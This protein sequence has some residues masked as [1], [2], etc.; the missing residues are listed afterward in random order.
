[1]TIKAKVTYNTIKTK[2]TQSFLQGKVE[3]IIHAQIFKI[4]P[5]NDL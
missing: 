5:L 1:M 3:H 2:V 4:F